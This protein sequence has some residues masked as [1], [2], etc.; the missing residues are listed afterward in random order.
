MTCADKYYESIDMAT[1]RHPQSLLCY[2][3]YD[4]PP[5]R[6]HGVPLRLQMP[7]TL[8]YNQA[9]YPVRVM[10]RPHAIR[11]FF[12]AA[13]LAVAG[14]AVP[15]ART[16]D[17]FDKTFATYRDLL[18]RFVRDGKVDYAALTS[19]RSVLDRSV[20]AFGRVA[21]ADEMAWPRGERI[22]FWINAYNLFTLRSIA[23]HYP[24]RGSVFT[25]YPRNSIRQIDGVWTTQH[26]SAAG[27]SV[28][29]DQIEHEILRPTFKDPRIH[30]TINCA[31]TSCPTLRS[32]PFVGSDIEAQLD[33]ATRRFLSSAQGARSVGSRLLVSSLFKWYGA[34]FAVS[35]TGVKG[36]AAIRAFIE[37]YGPPEAVRA[38]RA[39]APIRFLSYDWSLND[40]NR[41]QP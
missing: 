22:A 28:T 5:D 16:A 12:V 17:P 34:D 9:K 41:H 4:K 36:D 37:R 32:E 1:A 23:D 31:S 18:T 6:G 3:M 14:F 30:F 19:G 8:G 33:D 20:E 29:L 27:R 7:T 25:L 40:I 15:S 21:M 26:W 13:L 38:A 10:N 2:E 39:S 11:R 24:I 35:D